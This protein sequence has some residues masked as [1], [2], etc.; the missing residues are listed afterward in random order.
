M[1]DACILF[2]SLAILGPSAVGFAQATVRLS[3]TPDGQITGN[4]CYWGAMSPDF[5]SVG[6]VNSGMNLQP[7][8]THVNTGRYTSVT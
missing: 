5:R 6:W 8:A 7:P 2:V 1:R 4:S 3:Q